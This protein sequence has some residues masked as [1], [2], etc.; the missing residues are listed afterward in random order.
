[1][2]N[3][4]TLEV[5]ARLLG[6]ILQPLHVSL[7][8]P[9]DASGLFAKLG[10]N[11]EP[12]VLEDKAGSFL[13]AGSAASGALGPAVEQLNAAILSGKT[14]GIAA[15]GVQVL[16]KVA[17]V[18]T[19]LDSI[20]AQ[21]AAIAVQ[22]AAIDPA[23][24]AKLPRALLDHL[25]VRFLESS[26]DAVATTLVA[27]GLI[28][29]DSHPAG[30][31]AHPAFTSRTLRLDRL[32]KLLGDPKAHFQE[33]AG[34][35]ANL[36]PAKVLARLHKLF[37]DL[38]VDSNLSL[39]PLKL[40]AYIANF[41][42]LDGGLAFEIKTPIDLGMA[43]DLPLTPTLTFHLQTTG[44][45]VSGI[46]GTI[47][48]P[49]SIE[50]KAGNTPLEGN[51]AAGIS[52]KP[53]L[54]EPPVILFG[55]TGGS[56]LELASFRADAGLHFV[57]D[58]VA[59]AA[60]AE[61]QLSV[62]LGG[63]KIVID[64]SG[65]DGFVATLTNGFKMEAGFGVKMRWTPSGGAQFEGSSTIEIQLPVHVSIGPVDIPTIY[66]IAGL[67]TETIPIELSLGIAARLGPLTAVV[68]RIGA[69][70][71]LS[72]PGSGGNLG[73][74]DLALGFKPPS[75]IGLLLDAGI[76][77]GGGFLNYDEGR[78]EYS[79]A[80]ELTFSG[81]FSLKAVGLIA[82]KMPDGSKGFSLLI[83]ITADFGTGIPL[84]FGFTL[85]AVGGLLG[86][87]RTVDLQPLVEGVRTGAVDSVL[88]P[89][90]VIA[91]APKIISDLRTFFPP[92]QDMFLI[93]PMAKLGWG[94]PTLIT[95][96][97]GVIVEI[98][99]GNIA[100]AG[101]LRVV[102]PAADAPI[103]TL[104]AMFTGVF[105][106][107]KKRFY[108]FAGLFESRVLSTPVSGE[109]GLLMAYGDE[110]N[111][112]VSVGGF[113]PSFQPPPMPIPVPARVTIDLVNSPGAR[114]WVEGYFAVTS[115]TVQFGARASM[116]FGLD[117][118]NVEGYIGFDALFQF[119]PFYFAIT[120][121][122]S[123]SLNVFGIG[124][125][126]VGINGSLQ[127]PTPWRAAGTG[128]ISLLFFDVSADFDVTWGET[129]DTTLPPVA[130]LPELVAE[131]QKRENW[132]ALPPVSNNLLVALRP[133]PES[134]SLVLHPVGALRVVQRAL[135]LELTFDKYGNRKP[136]DVNRLRVDAAEGSGLKKTGTLDEQ[137]A[138]AQFQEMPAADKLSRP[139]YGPQQAGLEL[140]PAGVST[141]SSHC[142]KR[143]V[144]YEEH[145]VDSN[146]KRIILKFQLFSALLFNHFLAGS[147]A[148]QSSLSQATLKLH[149][150]FAA[151]IE[152][153]PETY[154]VALQSSNEAYGPAFSSEASARDFMLGEVAK[155]PNLA[156]VLHVIPSY[157]MAA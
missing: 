116:F 19:S 105:E 79:G 20:A 47:H 64:T 84:G 26:S 18:F 43:L 156:G 9:A 48:P 82:T 112:V 127:G 73:P 142:V 104:Q 3:Q 123:F 148:A 139:A 136:G 131:L 151:K 63:G 85:L 144:R 25:L 128:S 8:T 81:F 54:P 119:S 2:P 33:I 140:S 1:M 124:L 67:S 115:N 150:P 90:G 87:N 114:I 32:G 89:A 133:L 21:L 22:P 4:G 109:F 125:F 111:F 117:E 103:L 93:G 14:A 80:M 31:A 71:S 44:N 34:W 49:A 10:V 134:S 98:P 113:H 46:K 92:Q 65:A 59:K 55:Q 60:T 76:V 147:A 6:Q 155:D 70:A 69:R 30:D 149:Q 154:I 36:D 96:T 61:P 126:S 75:G 132:R 53:V 121:S 107:S 97:V 29:R 143:I 120:I 146:F 129:R 15:A 16:A 102:L 7:A 5:V 122:A 58:D 68:D 110:P 12:A 100:I 101:V 62:E 153:G 95:L 35:G 52:M 88:F 40:E 118:V 77:K 45:Y 152:V 137:F 57:W 91:N 24:A 41:E 78:G 157:E 138:P 72:F 51:L 145:I 99:S 23:F 42:P 130:I 141:K 135:P 106:P 74:A 50:V 37:L 83:L 94:T 13:S 39:A 38:S 66:L 56:R 28:D 27:V 11:I 86:V 108:L 17:G